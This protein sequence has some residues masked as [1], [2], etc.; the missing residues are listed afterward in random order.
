MWEA[1]QYQSPEVDDAGE[2]FVRFFEDHYFFAGNQ[3][4]KSVGRLFDELDE[5]GI[6]DD[7]FV[8]ETCQLNHGSRPFSSMTS[9]RN[10]SLS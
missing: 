1:L 10:E 7:G 3:G 8:V 6:H 4:D 2:N 5:I 9:R